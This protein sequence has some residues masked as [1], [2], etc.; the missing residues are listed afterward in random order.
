MTNSE[1]ESFWD[2]IKEGNLAAYKRELAPQD[3]IYTPAERRAMEIVLGQYLRRRKVSVKNKSYS[4]TFAANTLTPLALQE[5]LWDLEQMK[6][7]SDANLHI[8]KTGGADVRE[9]PMLTMRATWREE[10]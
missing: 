6:V 5:A 8:E 1:S 4:V 2:G 7:P 9:T 3:R 10:Q